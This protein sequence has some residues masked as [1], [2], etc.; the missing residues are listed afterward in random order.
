MKEELQQPAV[1]TARVATR[2]GPSGLAEYRRR[3]YQRHLLAFLAVCTLL[4]AIDR[5]TT[6]GI[7]WAHFPIVPWLLVFV[8]H[9]AGLLSRGYSIGELLIP[10][11]QAP[12]KDVYNVPLDYELVRSR[13]LHDGIRNAAHAVRSRDSQLADESTAAADE[14]VEAL[15]GLVARVRTEK[16][17]S[18][19]RAKQLVP[20]AQEALVAMDSLHQG[21]LKAQVLDE[22]TSDVPIEGVRERASAVRELAG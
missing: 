12:V 7:Q 2:P 21:L 16:Y 11:R 3:I 19:E 1:P 13:Q 5:V 4:I 10:P 17:R 8:M 14:L 15:E 18:D 6:P 9:T 22:P 20:V